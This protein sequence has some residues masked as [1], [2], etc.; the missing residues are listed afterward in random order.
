MADGFE[1]IHVKE[2]LQNWVLCGTVQAEDRAVID[3]C[4]D[5]IFLPTKQT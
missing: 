5:L 2:A 1:T 3:V 4:T